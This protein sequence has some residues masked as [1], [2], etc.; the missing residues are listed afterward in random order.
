MIGKAY[1]G[2]TNVTSCDVRADFDGVVG[3][4]GSIGGLVGIIGA[5][6]AW[7]CLV[8]GYGLI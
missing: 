3:G 1:R 8:F 2:E 6:T 7:V 4:N 5:A